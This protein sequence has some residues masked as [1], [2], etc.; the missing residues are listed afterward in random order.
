[1]TEVTISIVVFN[2]PYTVVVRCLA[3]VLQSIRF[4]RKASENRLRCSVCLINNSAPGLSER[5]ADEGV[6]SLFVKHGCVLSV[7]EG[8]GNVGYGKAQNLSIKQS[9]G[10]YSLI[11]NPDVRV[12]HDAILEGINYLETHDS[13]VALSPRCRSASGSRRYLCKSYPSIFNL[14][15]RGLAP[16]WARQLFRSRLSRYELKELQDAPNPSGVSIIS[17][18][19]MFCRAPVLRAVG[20]FDERFFLYFE[21]FDLSLRLSDRGRLKFIP[22]L[23][24]EHDG[25]GA[26]KKGLRHIGMFLSSAVKFFNKH[27]W[28]WF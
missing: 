2:T 15:L 4:A 11:M 22:T 23:T 9:S 27:G 21:D 3:F 13:V 20:G 16:S 19:F 26:S 18:C 12:A 17:G 25:G 7:M 28:R 14:F 6:G 8:H 5:L 10:E 24:I 1:M